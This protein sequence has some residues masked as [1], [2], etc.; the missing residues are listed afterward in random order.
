VQSAERAEDSQPPRTLAHACD[1]C[2]VLRTHTEECVEDGVQYRVET[3]WDDESGNAQIREFD[4]QGTLV[5]RCEWS[6]WPED[7][8]RGDLI[9]EAVWFDSTG[10]ELRR[11]P[12]RERPTAGP[13]DREPSEPGST[14]RSVDSR[15]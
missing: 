12:L 4:E 7:E 9:G 5:R 10:G 8:R 6:I 11:R 2:L 13:R 1:H 14:S 3:V 15:K